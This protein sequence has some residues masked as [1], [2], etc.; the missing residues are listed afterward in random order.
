MSKP[1]IHRVNGYTIL[2]IKSKSKT[3]YVSAI[4]ANGYCNEKESDIGVNHLLE[5]VLLESWKKCKQKPC[6]LY[7]MSKP[8]FFNGFTSMTQ[9]KYF[10]DGLS[11]ELPDMLEY[12]ID[13]VTKPMISEKSLTAEKK[14]VI[15]EMNQRINSL[16]YGFNQIVLNTLYT[17]PGLQQA[18]NYLLQK[19]NVETISLQ[20]LVEYHKK[21]YNSSNTYFVVSGEFNPAYVLSVLKKKLKL[22]SSSSSLPVASS[23]IPSKNPFSYQSKLFFVQNKTDEA[24]NG[25]VEFSLIFPIDIHM[26]NELLQHLLITCSII[27]KELYNILRIEHKLIYSIYVKYATYYYGTVVEIAGSCTD[28][29]IVKILKYI[30]SYLREKKKKHVNQKLINNVKK[31]MLLYRHNNIKNPMEIAEFYE[32]QY[33]L[34]QLQKRYRSPHSS[35]SNHEEEK[36]EEVQENASCKNCK[37][38][39]ET[40]FDKIIENVNA[41]HIQKIINMMDFGSIIIG[42]MGKKNLHLNLSDFI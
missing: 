23:N 41:K 20:D 6:D 36:E 31:L 1:I 32:S 3:A 16:D 22:V 24:K 13:I 37:I 29:N 27:E 12:I 34:N 25:G 14:I 30:T 28:S 26:N 11:D 9:M 7:W 19:K 15:N 4:I 33:I 35:S 10:I 2:F 5:H 40:E 17:L 18:N 42:Y 21:N 8:V 39:S 38:Y